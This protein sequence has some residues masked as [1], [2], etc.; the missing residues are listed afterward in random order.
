MQF[1]NSSGKYNSDLYEDTLF[2]V[3]SCSIANSI[4]FVATFKNKHNRK[5]NDYFHDPRSQSY[6][7]DRITNIQNDLSFL[8]AESKKYNEAINK[9]TKELSKKYKELGYEEMINNELLTNSKE[10]SN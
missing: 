6:F 1:L 7:N 10:L 9:K 2:V 5:I 8:I 4:M 3:S